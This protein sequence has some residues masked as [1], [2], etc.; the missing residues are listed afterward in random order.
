MKLI[1]RIY[2]PE[3]CKQKLISEE[4][5]ISSSNNSK[6]KKPR[7]LQDITN[8]NSPSITLNS[9]LDDFM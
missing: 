3:T 2:N 9:S 1:K 7:I 5:T 8:T 4:S 6:I